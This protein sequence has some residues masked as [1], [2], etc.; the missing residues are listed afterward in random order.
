MN[1]K[2]N[3]VLLAGLL[4][5][6]I[7]NMVLTDGQ[8]ADAID[9]DGNATMLGVGKLNCAQVSLLI[10][11]GDDT[12]KAAVG[13]FVS[14]WISA[15]NVNSFIGVDVSRGSEMDRIMTILMGGCRVAPEVNFGVAVQALI[16][17]FDKHYSKVEKEERNEREI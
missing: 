11:D 5:V 1:G 4:C 9:A 13:S 6:G 16:E 2:L 14:G 8:S 7:G 12:D 10:E 15:Y 17:T 3:T